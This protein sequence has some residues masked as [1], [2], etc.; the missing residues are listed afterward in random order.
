MARWSWPLSCPASCD[1]STWHA[2][3]GVDEVVGQPARALGDVG[4]RQPAVAEHEALGVGPG[5]GDRL[6]DLGHREL[7]R[8][9]LE[10]L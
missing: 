2:E 4:P 1:R 3:A 5:G 7:H 8:R 6:V 10:K 9:N